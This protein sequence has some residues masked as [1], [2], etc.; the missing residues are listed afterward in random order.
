MLLMPNS[1]ATIK[2]LI[3]TGDIFQ[4]VWVPVK[5]FWD[6][7]LFT[8]FVKH[9]YLSHHNLPVQ[10]YSTGVLIKLA[11][12]CMWLKVYLKRKIYCVGG[13]HVYAHTIC[14]KAWV[15]ELCL[16]M[17]PPQVLQ[18]VQ[19]GAYWNWSA[20]RQLNQ[21]ELTYFFTQCPGNRQILTNQ[22]WCHRVSLPHWSWLASV[23]TYYHVWEWVVGKVVPL[24]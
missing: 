19:T 13:Y 1:D 20:C 7:F 21:N 16:S 6:I 8:M 14:V 5:V 10:V 24:Q 9:G 22:S 12:E 18:N 2:R 17:A 4:K 15:Y 23:D 11:G 3:R